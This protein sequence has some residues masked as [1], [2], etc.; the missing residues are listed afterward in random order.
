[1]Y[2]KYQRTHSAKLANI[3]AGQPIHL[4][5]KM[6]MYNSATWANVSSGQSINLSRASATCIVSSGQP[7]N[8]DH[9]MKMHNQPHGQMFPPVSQ[10]TFPGPQ[11]RALFLQ[12][13]QSTELTK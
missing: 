8:L 1:M 9:K 7:I 4:D 10:S 12:V 11:P 2:S 6:K 5:H 13:S 3:S